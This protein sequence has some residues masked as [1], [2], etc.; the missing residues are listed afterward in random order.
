MVLLVGAVVAGVLTAAS[1]CVLPV[2]PVV[3]GGGLL[4]VDVAV[5]LCALAVSVIACSVL[6][7]AGTLL[8]AVPPQAWAVVSGG[9]LVALGLVQ[10]LP[11]AWDRAASA[12][13]LTSAPRLLPVGRS[14][15][16]VRGAALA[17]A[18]LGPVFASCSPL[19]A[20]VVATALPASPAWGSVLLLAYVAGLCGAL[21]A[22]AALGQ[23]AAR[24]LRWAA[25]PDGAVRRVA[26]LLFVAV[27]VAI[28]AGADKAVETWAVEHVPLTGLWTFDEHFLPGR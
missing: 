9:L 3:L 14:R 28:L 19:Y 15:Q 26:G 5:L 11:A 2:L 22:V 16:D 1:P 21:L 13:R 24:R 8:L 12:L 25:D 18:A 10:L 7:R 6:L 27:G 17:G 23:R 4:T 20:Y